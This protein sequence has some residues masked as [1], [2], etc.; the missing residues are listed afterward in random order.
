M[1]SRATYRNACAHLLVIFA[2]LYLLDH[3]FLFAQR[4]A[5]ALARVQILRAEKGMRQLFPVHGPRGRHEELVLAGED[6]CSFKFTDTT[7][8]RTSVAPLQP[9]ASSVLPLKLKRNDPRASLLA[10]SAPRNEATLYRIRDGR[11]LRPQ[12]TRAFDPPVEEAIA[13]DVTN[14]GRLDLLCF[15]KKESGIRVF[16][17]SADGSLGTPTTILAEYSFSFVEI[18]DFN[19]D[20]L[21]DI[22]AVNWITNEILV[23]TSFGKLKFTNPSRIPFP[24]EAAGLHAADFNRDG[25]TDLLAVS[26]DRHTM[27]LFN[28]DGFGAF[29]EGTTTD[30]DDTPRASRIADINGDGY[31]DVAALVGSSL[32]ILLNDGKGAL[33]ER[34]PFAAGRDPSDFC[35]VHRESGIAAAVLDSAAEEVRIITPAGDVPPGRTEDWYATGDGPGNVVAADLNDDGRDDLLVPNAGSRTLSLFLRSGDMPYEGQI[36][37]STTLPVERLVPVRTTDSTITVVGYRPN[38]DS[39][40]VLSLNFRNFGHQ[41]TLLPTQ[42]GIDLL[43]AHVDS[44]GDRLHIFTL[45]RNRDRSVSQIVE[46]E[47]ISPTRFT[48]RT[49]TSLT[50]DTLLA[51]AI[52]FDSSGTSPYLV[53]ATVSRKLQSVSLHLARS[54]TKGE[55]APSIEIGTIPVP[56]I[57]GAIIW[58]ADV[59]G[60]G[61]PDVLV[62]LQEPVNTLYVCVAKSDT[63]FAQPSAQ[64]AGSMKMLDRSDVQ[65]LDRQPGRFRSVLINNQ[66]ARM[67]QMYNV[68]PDGFFV[69]ATR[70]VSTQGIGGFTFLAGP[71]RST[72]TLVLSDHDGGY[73]RILPIEHLR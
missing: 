53:Y 16:P 51:A 42:G 73:L 9:P 72:G 4:S 64:F 40:A 58:I 41:S 8:W 60:D 38:E 66:L 46:Y 48:E 20:G 24:G 33:R 30:V 44:T 55:F 1:L 14:D 37:F 69:P 54:R 11:H 17:I 35:F 13:A 59:T 70:L 27:T 19:N 32:V 62:N 18:A 29:H 34:I 28:N 23:F 39:L 12:W 36:A 61:R 3:Q 47:Q 56:E 26:A 22:A 71:T 25:L 68:R 5:T 2:A 21:N 52:Y 63:A 15:G 49:Y 10:F 45:E 65:F 43:A 6:A 31:P 7:G 57:E 50:K 67:L